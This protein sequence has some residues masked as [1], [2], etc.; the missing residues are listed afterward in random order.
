MAAFMSSLIQKTLPNVGHG[1]SATSC[2]VPCPA[3]VGIV[4][5]TCFFRG[6]YDEPRATWGQG[7]GGVTVQVIRQAW[8]LRRAVSGK[9]TSVS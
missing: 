6:W 8:L 9:A 2:V 1:F 3:M 7:T 5:L 4:T